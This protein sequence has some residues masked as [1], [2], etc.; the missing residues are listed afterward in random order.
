MHKNK[1][2]N[3]FHKVR[4]KEKSY[5]EYK[6]SQK[7]INLEK[8]MQEPYQIPNLNSKEKVSQ[9]RPQNDKPPPLPIVYTQKKTSDIY[10]KIY[11]VGNCIGTE[12]PHH[13]PLNSTMDS[14]CL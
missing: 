5:R 14:I 7:E 2:Y 1:T 4:I 6:V 9:N 3:P 8:T 10:G 13:I 12:P 11:Q